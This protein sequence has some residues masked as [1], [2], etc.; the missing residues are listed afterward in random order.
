MRRV[1]QFGIA[2]ALAVSA[3]AST[4]GQRA[5]AVQSVSV[6]PSLG[7]ANNQVVTV[8]WS[9]LPTL[10]Y[11]FLVCDGDLISD[12]RCLITGQTATTPSGSV[13]I[14]V[15][16]S[17]VPSFG[18]VTPVD[19]LAIVADCNIAMFHFDFARQ[20]FLLQQIPISF[21]NE[22]GRPKVAVAPNT[23]IGDGDVVTLVLDHW[24]D[25]PSVQIDECR[26]DSTDCIPI[27]TV[28]TP[29][30]GATVSAPLHRYHT[31]GG[32]VR[33]CLLDATQCFVRAVGSVGGIPFTTQ[34]E[35]LFLRGEAF[36]LSLD[37]DVIAPSP[38]AVTV[39]ARGLADGFTYAA[40]ECTR[41][42]V[43]TSSVPLSVNGPGTGTA[44]V[45]ATD[46]I[47]GI[48]CLVNG[49]CSIEVAGTDSGVLDRRTVP[50]SFPLAPI[51]LSH[52]TGLADLQRVRIEGVVG[53]PGD[54]VVVRRCVSA[55]T[56][57]R[58]GRGNTT[59]V[60]SHPTVRDLGFYAHDVV[61][62]DFVGPY[63]RLSCRNH[64]CRYEVLINGVVRGSVP[65][66]FASP[67]P[68]VSVLPTSAVEGT[69]AHVVVRLSRAT[70]ATVEVTLTTRS[71]SASE[72]AIPLPDY[73]GT[74][75]TLRIPAGI[76]EAAVDIP[77]NNDGI[78]EEPE[79][80]S[81]EIGNPA[82]A[83][84]P[85]STSV[86]AVTITDAIPFN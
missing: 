68:R 81:V 35:I 71:G 22:V 77:I 79:T 52:R 25:A 14:T 64:P 76:T 84:L 83:R 53:T 4:S 28:P 82:G 5:G 32:V 46:E 78:T 45:A 85:A 57:S 8:A 70:N 17:F 36:R 80:F 18:N 59:M 44:T 38:R 3:V 26:F 11:Q 6:T 63:P 30:D 43:C 74:T 13:E 49:P 61:V 69:T 37:P 67:P 10:A 20:T 9:G 29:A 51:A 2:L 27:A 15:S 54:A 7:L 41:S 72:F 48:S 33:D 50:V 23:H 12:Q 60:F 73:V 21:A 66:T 19:C 47:D 24:G 75:V 31:V 40:R 86:A 55:P 16:S 56:V 42:G 65:V 34:T 62:R 58:C 1:A 39:S